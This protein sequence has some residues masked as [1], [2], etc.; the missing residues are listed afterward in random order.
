VTFAAGQ[1]GSID[2]GKPGHDE[3]IPINDRREDSPMKSVRF[4]KNSQESVATTLNSIYNS[5]EIASRSVS[6]AAEE[7]EEGRQRSRPVHDQKL[8]VANAMQ[9]LK[10]IKHVR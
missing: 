1:L 8:M 9:A 6:S 7:N 10:S 5:V 3:N 2:A 4:G